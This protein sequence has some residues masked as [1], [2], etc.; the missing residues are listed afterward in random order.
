MFK[1]FPVS[2][3]KPYGKGRVFYSVLGHNKATFHNPLVLQHWM[4]GLQYVLG[5]KA[6]DD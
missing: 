5:D 6:I 1:N 4:E 2:W 3:V